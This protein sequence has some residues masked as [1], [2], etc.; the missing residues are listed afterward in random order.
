MSARLLPVYA[1]AA[2]IALLVAAGVWAW[3]AEPLSLER[4]LAALQRYAREP[5]APFVVLLVYVVG[6]LVLVPV[7]ALIAATGLAFGPVYGAVYALGGALASGC[8][9]F[10][11]GRYL[12]AGLLQRYAGPRLEAARAALQSRGLL[13]VIAVRI[14]PSGP[15][16]L[17][18]AVAGASGIRLRDFVLGTLIGMAPGVIATMGLVQGAQAAWAA[19]GPRTVAALALVVLALAALG[20]GLRRALARWCSRHH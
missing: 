9:S 17:V 20:Y 6:G 14:V 8:C 4:L 7:M 3:H 1:A 12:T 19:P 5:A 18:N 10:L 11:L 15:F 13:A 2:L 16:T